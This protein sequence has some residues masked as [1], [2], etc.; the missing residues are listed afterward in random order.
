MTEHRINCTAAE[1]RAYQ[2][3][4][5][6]LR[7]L[8][9]PQPDDNV[10]GFPYWHVGGYRL[11]HNATNPL[12]SPFGS[13]GDTLVLVPRGCQHQYYYWVTVRRVTVEQVDGVWWWACE[14][15]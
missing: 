3:G 13:P 2:S 5:R 11:W 9:K 15:E 14:V 6:T 7:R 1:I 8:V 12:R 4:E 10:C